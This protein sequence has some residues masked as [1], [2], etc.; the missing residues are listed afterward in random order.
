MI[1]HT[2]NAVVLELNKQMKSIGLDGRVSV[3]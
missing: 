3:G 1:R 2:F